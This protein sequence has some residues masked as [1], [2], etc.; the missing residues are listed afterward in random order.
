MCRDINWIDTLVHAHPHKKGIRDNPYFLLNDVFNRMGSIFNVYMEEDVVLS[1]DAFRMADWY[2]EQ[3]RANQE[4]WLSL[5]FF[6][7]GTKPDDP[8]GIM[9]SKNFSALGMCITKPAWDRWFRPNWYDDA[10]AARVHG[11]KD[12]QGWDWSMTATLATEAPLMTLT[13]LFSRSN[14]IGRD[15]GVHATP[16]F[17]DQT[18][19]HLKINTDPNPGEYVIR[20]PDGSIT[21]YV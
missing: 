21:T 12:H 10:K 20:S 2:Y 1:P 17:H 7:P 9:E 4:R 19:R 13:P 3:T 16:Q 18:F 11:E 5:N 8:V 6:H 14:H 15:D